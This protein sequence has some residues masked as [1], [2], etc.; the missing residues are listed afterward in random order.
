MVRV[1]RARLGDRFMSE[2]ERYGKEL[3]EATGRPFDVEDY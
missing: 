3:E 2:A 1:L